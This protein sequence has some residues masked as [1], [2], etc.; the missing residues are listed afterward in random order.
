MKSITKTLNIAAVVALLAFPVSAHA[1]DV[2]Q[3]TFGIVD[4]NVVMNDADAGKT[5]YSELKAK[6]DEYMAQL[7][8][9]DEA[10][11]S[12][13][14]AFLKEKDKFSKEETQKKVDELNKLQQS[15]QK[16]VQERE[17]TLGIALDKSKGKLREKIA[18]V[19]AKIA[20]EKGYITVFTQDAVMIAS[21][22][23][24]I[25]DAVLAR[26]NSDVKKID[27]DWSGKK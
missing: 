16:T 11:V 1:A 8:K 23:I 22:E 12:K 26:M 27:V 3:G 21:K 17:Q 25:T 2:V 15:L 10:F 4:V 5:L 9:Q 24:D 6:R 18:E 20:K 7:K 14:D 19:V 13:K